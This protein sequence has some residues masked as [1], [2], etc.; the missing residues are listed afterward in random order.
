MI[1]TYAS[2]T[3]KRLDKQI[4]RIAERSDILR[5]LDPKNKFE[6]L[7]IFIQFEGDYNPQFTYDEKH[8]PI[9]IEVIEYVSKLKEK[10][11]K[12]KTDNELKSVMIEKCNELL[13]KFQL[14]QAYHDQDLEKIASY[15]QQ[16]FGHFQDFSQ[17]CINYKQIESDY[18]IHFE[19]L[20]SPLGFEH[21]ETLGRKELRS[22]VEYHLELIGLERYH[23][24]FW[25]HG[26]TNMQVSIGPKPVVYINKKAKYNAKDVCISILHEIYGHLARYQAGIKS[27]IHM[28]Q[29]WTAH[30]L[31]TEEG[32]AVFQA[33]R[34]EW[35][36]IV[37]KRSIDSYN[38]LIQATQ[39]NRK[40]MTIYFK[41]LW[42]SN[43]ESIF[44][45]IL[46]L[47]R[48]LKDTSIVWPAGLFHKD[49]V[50]ADGYFQIINYISKQWN[51]AWILNSLMLGRIK[52]E[53]IL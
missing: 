12:L 4:M 35:F 40:E 39:N 37:W 29:G 27:G 28:L 23:I 2:I 41:K 53:D 36:E 22:L 43:L 30:Y 31:T 48:G 26:N 47:K 3:Q 6:E 8:I 45:S 51:K 1:Y 46:R 25:K 49:K 10:T 21:H 18:S 11:S 24:S 33:A 52:V 14:L 13:C 9:L 19:S 44:W 7:K 15:N 50:Y 38:N 16:L 20:L 34:I 5:F 32:I 17:S 42:Y